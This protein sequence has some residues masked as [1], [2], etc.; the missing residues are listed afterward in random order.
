MLNKKGIKYYYKE[1]IMIFHLNK[2][3]IISFSNLLI[4]FILFQIP[5]ISCTYWQKEHQL[6]S[7]ENPIKLYFTPS[8]NAETISKNSR[9]FIRYLEQKTGLYF[10]TAV[11]SSYI[12][13]VEAFG[14]NRADI[15]I[16]NAFGYILANKKYGV[17]AKYTVVR[18]GIT[19][20]QGQI[21][22]HVDSG[23]KKLEDL[24][25]KRFAFTDSS[26]SSGFLFPS[27]IFKEKNIKP[28]QTVFAMK[29]DNVITM[30]Y[31]K[32]VDAGATYYAPPSPDGTIHDARNL[33]MTRFPD[34]IKKIK[35]IHLTD[36]IRNDP[37]V[38][39]KDL[40]SHIETKL[41]D[42]IL[43]YLKT[44][45]GKKVLYDIYGIDGLIPT[46]DV[47]Y[48]QLRLAVKS[49]EIYK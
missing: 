17:K 29:H 24:N 23:V 39:R 13:V 46:K 27:K 16:M 1:F 9:E 26:S 47:D 44:E 38:V 14:S 18:N 25:G 11:A 21:I 10:K 40:P 28:S 22:T 36:K 2:Y 31:Q 37:L 35:I 48:D 5:T 42:A 12:A 20:Y 8:V 19:Y 34:V 45:K 30:I 49:S 15:G 4:I 3:L 32:Q 6:G 33:V 41:L 43:T 7:K